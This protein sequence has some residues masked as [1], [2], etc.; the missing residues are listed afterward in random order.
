MNQNKLKR[1]SNGIWVYKQE[2]EAALDLSEYPHIHDALDNKDTQ[3]LKMFC[4]LQGLPLF[5]GYSD[6]YGN[7]ERMLTNRLKYLW[8]KVEQSIQE[9]DTEN[10][11]GHRIWLQSGI[12]DLQEQ[13][14][15]LRI[16]KLK[17][18]HKEK[19]TCRYG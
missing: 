10:N 9:W 3:P 4:K 8:G 18:K 5:D 2:G 12:L 16:E 17:A 7:R 1:G 13:L 14:Y 6:Y 15:D 19:T 11:K